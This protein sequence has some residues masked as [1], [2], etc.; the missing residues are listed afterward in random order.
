MEEFYDDDDSSYEDEWVDP[1]AL[2]EEL[3]EETNWDLEDE[4]PDADSPCG[5][6]GVD[7]WVTKCSSCSTLLCKE[8]LSEGEVDGDLLCP[9]CGAT[10]EAP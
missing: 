1:D 2:A 6:C 4:G 8:C 5:A 10:V 7:D 3:E 9:V